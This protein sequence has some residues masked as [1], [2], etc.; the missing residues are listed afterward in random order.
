MFDKNQ[1]N[2][3]KARKKGVWATQTELVLSR[4]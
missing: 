2:I 3:L 4:S 1:Q